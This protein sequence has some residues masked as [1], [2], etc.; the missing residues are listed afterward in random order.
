MALDFEVEGQRKRGWLKRTWKKHVEEE[1]VK[2]GLRRKD[3]LCL[4]KWIVSI[5]KIAAALR[6]GCYHILSIG[7]SLS[8]QQY[9]VGPNGYFHTIHTFTRF[10]NSVVYDIICRRCHVICTGEAGCCLADGITEHIIS[11]QINF[12]D[13]AGAQHLSLPS[14]RFLKDF[15]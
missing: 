2:V 1:S 4:S 13:F 10:Y 5:N 9:M 11:I 12:S 14:H 7:V 15:L 3:A 6:C 8:Y